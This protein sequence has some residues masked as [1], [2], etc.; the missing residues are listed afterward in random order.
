MEKENNGLRKKDE[1]REDEKKNYK[2]N[3][4][5]VKLSEELDIPV[6]KDL[7]RDGKKFGLEGMDEASETFAKIN[8]KTMKIE[9]I[10]LF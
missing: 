10:Y 6:M 2:M 5:I 3:Y 1:S 9:Y 7:F 4:V 8:A